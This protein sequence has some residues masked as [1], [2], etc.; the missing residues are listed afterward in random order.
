MSRMG[1]RLID[2]PEDVELTITDDEVTAEGPEGTLSEPIPE[3]ISINR[4]DDQLSVDRDDDSKKSKSQHG[5]LWR[6]TKNIVRDVNEGYSKTLELN[7]IGYR[8]RKQG[9]TLVLEL[10]YSHP[11]EV[12]IPDEINVE[13]PNNTTITVSG[14]DRQ[15]VGEFAAQLRQLRDPDPYNQKGIKY[16]DEDIRQKVGKAVG[17]E[18]AEGEGAEGAAGP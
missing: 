16:E 1:N 15:Q 3:G 18:G 11:V 17:G 9:D 5:L 14:V 7:G 4:Q 8:T 10:G 2:V 6:L 12:E 13:V